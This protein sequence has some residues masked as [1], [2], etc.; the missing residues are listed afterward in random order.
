MDVN[1]TAF[2]NYTTP[3]MH[4]AEIYPPWLFSIKYP[5]KIHFVS[6]ASRF[7]YGRADVGGSVVQTLRSHCHFVPLCNHDDYKPGL[8]FTIKIL[9]KDFTVAG[10]RQRIRTP[11][12]PQIATMGGWMSMKPKSLTGS[13]TCCARVCVCLSIYML[14]VPGHNAKKHRPTVA[15]SNVHARQVHEWP[16]SQINI[17]DGY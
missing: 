14:R 6:R 13:L 11:P 7:P 2:R 12:I 5:H 15:D 16:A 4:T 17:Q 3:S 9:A 1:A 10:T 8:D